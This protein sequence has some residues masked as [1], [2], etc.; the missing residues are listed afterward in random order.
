MALTL[1]G[2]TPG[3]ALNAPS[4]LVAAMLAPRSA[5]SIDRAL[6]EAEATLGPLPSV[7]DAPVP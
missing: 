6:R 4:P 5:G 1:R 2:P 7:A 3:G